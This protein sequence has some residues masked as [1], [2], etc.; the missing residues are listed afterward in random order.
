MNLS[1][2]IVEDED[3]HKNHLVY[4]IQ[5]WAKKKEIEIKTVEF[6]T[7]NLFIQAYGKNSLFDAVFLDIYLPDGNGMEIAQIIRKY[8]TFIP[9]AFITQSNEFVSQGYNV[10][11]M[12]YLM[13]PVS[14]QEIALCLERIIELK[15]QFMDQTFSFKF[16]GIIRVLD[17]KDILYFTSFQH[18]VEIYTVKGQYR[19][20]ENINNL[21]ERLPEQFTRCNRSTIV[22]LSHLYLYNAQTTSKSI[23]LSNGKLIPV[24]EGYA[25]TVKEK[26]FNIVY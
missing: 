22:N 14:Y 20:R 7:A 25:K 26:C 1:I 4:L 15:K 10:W 8:D 9:I 6:R 13:K 11:A 3:L 17:C 21:E 16:E 5:S 12:H 18:Y 2:A 24:S 19:F 23:I